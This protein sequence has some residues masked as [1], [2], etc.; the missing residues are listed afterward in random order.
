MDYLSLVSLP[1]PA[2]D[3]VAPANIKQPSTSV[4]TVVSDEPS[5]SAPS[6]ES[7]T[8]PV[9]SM[10]SSQGP[11]AL[12]PSSSTQG[13]LLSSS[14]LKAHDELSDE[15]ARMATQLRRNAE[16]FSA[17]L[18]K[19]KGL[20]VS[21]E[22]ALSKNADSMTRERDRLKKHSSKSFGTTWFTIGTILVVCLAF[23]WMLVIMRVT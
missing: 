7:P 5:P 17:I 12:L 8:I 9:S 22:D 2:E 21:A 14:S 1:P 19:D 20:V 23:V 4:E 18:E 10:P 13:S 15:L 11:A 6:T 16:H 3:I